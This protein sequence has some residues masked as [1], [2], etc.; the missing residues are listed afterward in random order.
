MVHNARAS[1]FADP[2]DVR[3]FKRCKAAGHSDKYC[4][5]YGDNGV[6]YWGDDTS[7]GSGPSCAL[8][9]DDMRETWGSVANAHLKEVEVTIGEASVICQ[10]KDTMPPRAYQLAHNGAGIDLNVD[11]VRAL[12]L[13]PPLMENA[14]WESVDE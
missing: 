9:P 4:F 11:A 14:T 2:A 7:E 10:V 1:S 6:G 12:G 13:E 3:A 5:G 8:T